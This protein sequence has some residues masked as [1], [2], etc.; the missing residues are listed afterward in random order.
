MLAR[1]EEFETMVSFLHQQ[2]AASCGLTNSLTD[3]IQNKD[4]LQ[5]LFD[6]ID[7]LER[8]VEHVKA[9]VNRLENKVEEAEKNL[10]IMPSFQIKSLLKPLL[11]RF[12]LLFIDLFLLFFFL[13]KLSTE[14]P[15]SEPST[16]EE[17]RASDYFTR[18][19]DE[20]ETT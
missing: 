16:L 4:E 2:N 14:P 15:S 20:N 9:T 8:M 13:Q 17:F 5:Q 7:A 3:V 12:I 19:G 6:R 10:G 11:V 1:L 18:S